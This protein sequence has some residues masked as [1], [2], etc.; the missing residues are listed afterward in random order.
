VSELLDRIQREI[1][2]RLEASRAAAREHERLEAALHALGA[3]GAPATGPWQVA[4]TVR[5]RRLAQRVRRAPRAS[6]RALRHARASGRRPADPSA[7]RA[8]ALRASAPRRAPTVRPCYVWCASGRASPRVNWRPLRRSQAAR[9]T[10]SCADSCRRGRSRNASCLA[11]RPATRSRRA[12]RR[13]P[14][15]PQRVHPTRRTSGRRPARDG[16]SAPA[17]AASY[18]GVVSKRATSP[19]ISGTRMNLGLRARWIPSC[20]GARPVL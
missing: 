3:A 15:Q 7:P 8:V 12:L 4:V 1:H 9:F 2:E 14:K 6:P 16:A 17:S 18:P 10:R 13:R 19:A 11:D 20:R 5:R